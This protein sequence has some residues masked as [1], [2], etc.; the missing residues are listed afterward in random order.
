MNLIPV[1][2][3]VDDDPAVSQAISV[4]A[5]SFGY[6][7]AL[8][9]SAEDFLYGYD[10]TQPGCILLDVKMPGMSGLELQ[11]MLRSAGVRL[12]VIMMSGHGDIQMAV[13]AMTNGA[14]TFLEKPFRMQVLG[15]QIAKAIELDKKDRD[16]REQQ[17]T[18]REK[19]ESLTDKEKTVLIEI[20]NGLTNRQIADK[21]NLSVRAIEDRR[22]RAMKKLKINSIVELVTILNLGSTSADQNLQS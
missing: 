12:P 21:L 20:A 16:E 4:V 2:N 22:S 19:L 18:A 5:R 11:R 1:I 7:V 14:V 3:V 8:Y 17:I 13:D 15:D 9:K 10:D 6:R